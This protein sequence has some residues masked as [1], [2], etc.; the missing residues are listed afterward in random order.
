MERRSVDDAE[1]REA[2]EKLD[3][4]VVELGDLLARIPNEY[5]VLSRADGAGVS[6]ET[7]GGSWIPI[8]RELSERSTPDITASYQ[9]GRELER[10]RMD[11]YLG[12]ALGIFLFKARSE[13]AAR[14]G[15]A[16]S[17]HIRNQITGA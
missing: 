3:Q 4:R 11:S 13:L 12:T 7:P 2:L 1:I 14:D 15:G 10:Y 9:L 8:Y 16:P 17:Q 5:L 6:S